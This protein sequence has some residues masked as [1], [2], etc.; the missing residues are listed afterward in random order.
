MISERERT[1]L[2]IVLALLG[3]YVAFRGT[4]ALIV[5]PIRAR[6]QRLEAL[7]GD[8]E[9]RREQEKQVLA[10]ADRWRE[11]RDQSL[12]SDA[13]LAQSLYQEFL[14]GLVETV[15]LQGATVATL[16][17]APQGDVFVRYPYTVRA[18]GS[19]EQLVRLLDGIYSM[20]LLHQVRQLRVWRAD[21]GNLLEMELRVEALSLND[22]GEGAEKEL[23]SWRDRLKDLRTRPLMAYADLLQKN[24]FEPY[25]PPRPRQ[26]VVRSE[27]SPSVNPRR[28]VY[29]VGC[30]RVGSVAE[31]WLYDRLSNVL[32]RLVPGQAVTVAGWEG[33]LVEAGEGFAVFKVREGYF[34]LRL[35]QSLVELSP[36]SAPSG[37]VGSP[38]PAA[39]T[40]A[41]DV[42]R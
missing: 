9:A 8:V 24:I 6:D 15:G 19:P 37:A 4:M 7:R 42:V 29:F 2:L 28:F 27:A 31:A 23:R 39:V 22:A 5:D 13:R 32:H 26:P 17:P 18:R 11:W 25:T 21:Q 20:K 35:G 34:Q 38:S 30:V 1:L 36:L 16:S 33:Q 10:A 14:L 41:A 12:P 3:A 40:A